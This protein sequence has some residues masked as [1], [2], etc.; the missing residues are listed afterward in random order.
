LGAFLQ[1][2]PRRDI[3]RYWDLAA[4][5]SYKPLEIARYFEN[6]I[7][8]TGSLLTA[9]SANIHLYQVVL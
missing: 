4:T 8:E 5:E 9:S 3:E 6:P 1:V 7:S 2:A